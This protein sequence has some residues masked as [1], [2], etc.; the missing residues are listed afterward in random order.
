MLKTSVVVTLLFIIFSGC[1]STVPPKIYLPSQNSETAA[2]YRN[3]LPIGATQTGAILLMTSLE[4]AEISGKHYMR[5]WLLYKNAV[6]SAYL[7]EPLKMVKL[8]VIGNKKTYSDIGPESPTKVLARIENEKASKLIMQ[9]I[10]GTL[11]ALSTQPTTVTDPAG[12]VW[13]VNDKGTKIKAVVNNTTEAMANTSILYDVFKT[14]INSGILRRNT[15]LTGESANGYMYFPLPTL[16]TASGGIIAINPEKYK[17]V[18]TISSQ[19]GDKSIEFI[20]A[21]GE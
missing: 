15:L 1:A 7:L 4:P 20:P 12:D 9:A 16:T 2:Y 18:F 19:A 10:G 13:T 14:S 3:G 11:E 17:F 21:E 8:T 6:D 5:L